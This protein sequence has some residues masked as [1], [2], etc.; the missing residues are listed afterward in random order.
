VVALISGLL[1][2]KRN[3]NP[4]LLKGAGIKSVRITDKGHPE[5]ET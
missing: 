2:K 5:G 4:D 1:V 3:R